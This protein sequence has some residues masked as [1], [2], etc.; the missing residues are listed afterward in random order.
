MKLCQTLLFILA[1]VA[2][3]KVLP[4]QYDEDLDELGLDQSPNSKGKSILLGNRCA[5]RY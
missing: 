3:A 5:A 1:G 2:A 4:R